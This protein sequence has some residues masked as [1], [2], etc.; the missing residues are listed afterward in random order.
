[1]SSVIAGAGNSSETGNGTHNKVTAG[2][3][4][5]VADDGDN[6]GLN[7][8]EE[9]MDD[10]KIDGLL[11]G[12]LVRVVES[13]V[14]LSASSYELQE[15]LN[16]PD[17]SGFTLLHYA[18]LYNLQSLVPVLL[19]KGANPDTPT[20]HRKLTPLHLACSAGNWAIVELLSRNGCAIKVSDSQNLFPADHAARNGFPE[21][22]QWLRDKSGDD[23]KKQADLRAL[24]EQRQNDLMELEGEAHAFCSDGSSHIVP[25]LGLVVGEEGK[26]HVLQAAFSNLSLKDKLAFNLLV[27]MRQETIAARPCAGDTLA[28]GE[29]ESSLNDMD[30]AENKPGELSMRDKQ[31]QR[32]GRLEASMSEID[33][34]VGSVISE[35]DKASLNIA[36]RLMNEEELED[37]EMRAG[38]IDQD[39]RK[40]MLKRNYET[41]KEASV[42]LKR[43]KELHEKNCWRDGGKS[44]VLGSRGASQKATS[45]AT[46]KEQRAAKRTLQNVKSQALAGLVIRKNMAGFRAGVGAGSVPSFKPS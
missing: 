9:N 10:D 35:S 17:K 25:G 19:S 23:A 41:L 42:Y 30:D 27:K 21:I 36:M 28:A 5:V 29:G 38:D 14:G 8:D 44:P 26:K 16:A 24:D 20:V 7:L 12:L 1:M 22:A 18:S 2:N 32:Y 31:R 6:L 11:D 46:R 33:F 15:E 3:Y 13:L 45:A 37:L 34:D 4:A 40:W 39:L 43:T